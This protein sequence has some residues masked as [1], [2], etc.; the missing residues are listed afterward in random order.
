[1]TEEL[2]DLQRKVLAVVQNGFPTTK[3]PYRDMAGRIGVGTADFLKVL[4][5]WAK[6]GKVR[7]VGA[8][9][10]HFKVGIGAGGMV[11]WE[12]AS[13]RVEE[14]GKIFAGF[15]QVS[16]AYERAVTAWW[17]YN[18]YTMVHGG[19]SEEV[20]ETVRQ[21]SISAGVDKYRILVTERELKKVP[22]TYIG[23][24]EV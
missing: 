13:D 20:E 12:V 17:P 8:I 18:V 6:E 24:S 11:V 10:N 3:T 9:V 4:T 5:D 16:H 1:M 22:P 14:V 7:R 23:D 19:S 15:Q 2:S 21:M